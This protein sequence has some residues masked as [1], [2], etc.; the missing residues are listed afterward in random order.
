MIVGGR[1]GLIGTIMPSIFAAGRVAT[2][3][4]ARMV[5]AGCADR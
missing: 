3:K 2:G 5:V 4:H 1:E